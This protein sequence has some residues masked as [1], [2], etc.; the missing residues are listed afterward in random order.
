MNFFQNR[1]SSKTKVMEEKMEEIRQNGSNFNDGSSSASAGVESAEAAIQNVV[2]IA[3]NPVP[4][5]VQFKSENEA[6]DSLRN[7]QQNDQQID[8][9]ESPSD[10][11]G[12]IDNGLETPPLDAEADTRTFLPYHLIHPQPQAQIQ[13][14]M[15]GQGVLQSN[16]HAQFGICGGN[17]DSG[18]G[19]PSSGIGS[20]FSAGIHGALGSAAFR[21]TR[22]RGGI[23]L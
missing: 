19:A 4:Q 18:D 20:G 14:I 15:F 9:P 7:Q 1:E 16:L 6:H 22:G 5:N 13:Q 23:V 8:G 3:S 21:G 11:N 2:Q 10:N 17:D 12:S